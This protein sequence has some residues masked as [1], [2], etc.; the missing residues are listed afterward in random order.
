MN[1]PKCQATLIRLPEGFRCQCKGSKAPTF[2]AV[3][4]DVFQAVDRSE[5]VGCKPSPRKPSPR[6][7]RILKHHGGA[8]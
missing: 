5:R 3:P 2:E 7:P 1:C 4:L 6:T 8:A